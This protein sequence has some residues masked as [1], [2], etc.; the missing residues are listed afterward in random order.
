[1]YGWTESTIN[2]YAEWR[3]SNNDIKNVVP[4]QTYFKTNKETYTVASLLR[5]NEKTHYYYHIIERLTTFVL[6][7]IRFFSIYLKS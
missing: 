5:V 2:C 4:A 7:Q 6:L 1:M 3:E